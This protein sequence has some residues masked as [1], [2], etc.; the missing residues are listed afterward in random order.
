[1]T[2][3]RNEETGAEVATSTHSKVFKVAGDVLPDEF[4]EM[5]IEAS[6]DLTAEEVDQLVKLIEYSWVT[7][8]RGQE[9]T[10]FDSEN[11][12]AFTVG[13]DLTRSFSH[14]PVGRAKEF[15]DGLNAF[16]ASGSPQRKTKNN[17]RAVEPLPNT[18]VTVWVTDVY[19]NA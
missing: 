15:V 8:A 7:T 11:Q 16:I 4:R 1:M 19:K 10:F 9:F 13:A 12:R 2:V 3:L 18:T 17:T 6:R 5:R 14:D